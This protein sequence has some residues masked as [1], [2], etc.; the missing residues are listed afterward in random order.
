MTVYGGMTDWDV[1]EVCGGWDTHEFLST[2]PPSVWLCDEHATEVEDPDRWH[3]I[4]G[5]R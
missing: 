2:T 4:A 5:D 3:A 1:C